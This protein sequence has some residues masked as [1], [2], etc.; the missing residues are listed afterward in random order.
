MFNKI[1]NS[2][3]FKKGFFKISF[4]IFVFSF[5][6]NTNITK[7]ET[8][9]INIDESPFSNI[10]DPVNYANEDRY[11]FDISFTINGLSFKKGD[12][13]FIGNPTFTSQYFCSHTFP[14]CYLHNFIPGSVQLNSLILRIGTSTQDVVNNYTVDDNINYGNNQDACFLLNIAFISI[15]GTDSNSENNTYCSEQKINILTAASA[16]TAPNLYVR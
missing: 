12:Q 1:F 3:F 2:S 6:I 7:A 14:N 9:I 16:N 5:F 15:S 11:K 13:I 10:T 8:I 4:L